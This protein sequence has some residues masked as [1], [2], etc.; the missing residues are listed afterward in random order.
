MEK[1]KLEIGFFKKQDWAGCNLRTHFKY[2]GTAK[3][4]S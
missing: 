4:K 1:G 3:V 2:K